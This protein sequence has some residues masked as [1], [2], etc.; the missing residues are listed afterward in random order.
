M[1]LYFSSNSDSLTLSSIIASYFIGE[2]YCKKNISIETTTGIR[3]TKI[4]TILCPLLKMEITTNNDQIPKTNN[5]NRTPKL[6][7]I[8]LIS[9]SIL[10]PSKT[11]HSYHSTLFS[12]DYSFI[13]ILYLILRFITRLYL[14]RILDKYNCHLLYYSFPHHILYN[15]FIHS[16]ILTTIQ[17]SLCYQ[18][19]RL[20][21]ESI[22]NFRLLRNK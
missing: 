15:S 19:Y 13:I 10:T 1:I 18:V 20:Y 8:G 14:C 4:G 7:D 21:L 5:T 9:F 6:T 12:S 3:L 22:Y 16:P 17:S 2:V 11:H